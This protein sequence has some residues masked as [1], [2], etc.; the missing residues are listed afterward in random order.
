MTVK[1]IR[2]VF[3][4]WENLEAVDKFLR[5]ISATKIKSRWHEQFAQ[6]YKW[7]MRLKYNEQLMQQS[8]NQ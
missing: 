1:S 8:P 3:E 7:T 4:I 6:I 5:H 2:K